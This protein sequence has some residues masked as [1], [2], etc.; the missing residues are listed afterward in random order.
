MNM[1][2]KNKNGLGAKNGFPDPKKTNC[3]QCSEE[4]WIRWVNPRQEYSH[5]NDWDYWTGENS[6][7]KICNSC[8]CALYYNKKVYWETVKDIKKKRRLA[9]Y[10]S[11][12][13]I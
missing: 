10:I 6:K 12:N 9:A 2:D 3:F 11:S 13:S 1:E 4:F 5:K 8:L 7:K